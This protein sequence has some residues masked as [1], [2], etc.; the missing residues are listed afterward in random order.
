MLSISLA[1]RWAKCSKKTGSRAS[2]SMHEQGAGWASRHH[3]EETVG[4]PVLRRQH[5][6]PSGVEFPDLHVKNG[7]PLPPSLDGQGPRTVG[8]LI[9]PPYSQR[10]GRRS[11]DEV[12]KLCLTAPVGHEGMQP[13]QKPR[14]PVKRR[15][16]ETASTKP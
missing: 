6:P 1:Q 16:C 5:E 15:T 10:M 11:E 8:E 12:V 9:G 3:T 4:C 13:C 7:K 2:Q 14:R